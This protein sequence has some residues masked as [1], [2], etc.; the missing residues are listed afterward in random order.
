MT[1]KMN[2]KESETLELKKSTAEL[3][4]AVISISAILNKHARGDVYFGIKNDGTVVGQD[5]SETTIRKIS[6][7][8]GEN[9]EPKIYPEI[10]PIKIKGIDCIHVKF[11][12]GDSPYY[13]FGRAFIRVGD[14]DRKL[15]AKELENK[16]LEKNKPQP[17]WD[18]RPCPNAEIKDISVEKIKRFLNEAGLKYSGLQNDLEKLN[19]LHKDKPLN[20]TL[21]LFG[22]KPPR[23]FPNARL[24]CAVFGATNTAYIID[25][26]EYSGDLFYLIEK[27]EEYI[28]KNIHIGMKLNGL[29]RV[30]V[31]EIDQQAYREAILNAFCHRDYN[32]YDSVN[33]AVFKD[34]V[35]IRNPGG[36]L[37][38]LTI[39][40]IKSEMVSKRRNEII[41]EMLN[42]VHYIEKWGRGISL[43]LEKE[44]GTVFK[45]VAGMF[46]TVFKRK[47]Y[48]GASPAQET[49][50]A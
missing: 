34:R 49:G 47:N 15:S 26:Q 28:L 37:G 36:L 19:L 29:Y 16:I 39:E 7:A 42:R 45:E 17:G 46:I 22:K 50:P 18:N 24:R 4:N 38:G 40:Q 3:K 2:F 31:P 6:Q 35:E 5:I 32:E 41:A 8:I 23:F 14:E 1:T 10:T 25:R 48:P 20:S 33:I 27:A 43:I 13:A 30:D 21:L 11:S 12:G 44:P 9:I